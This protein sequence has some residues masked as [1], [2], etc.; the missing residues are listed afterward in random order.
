MPTTSMSG[1]S[2]AL[3]TCRQGGPWHTNPP[4]S[5]CVRPGHAHHLEDGMHQDVTQVTALLE[6][7]K[8]RAVAIASG[9]LDEA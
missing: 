8:D 9:K 7:L 3:R 5:R 2:T 1:F 6:E 4:Q